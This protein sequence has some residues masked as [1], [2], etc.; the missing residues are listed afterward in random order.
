MRYASSGRYA[1][2]LAAASLAACGGLGAPVATPGGLSNPAINKSQS[3]LYVTDGSNSVY[4]V[5]LP[6]GRLA[7]KL[8]GLDNPAGLCVDRSGDVFVLNSGQA[9]IRVYAHGAKSAFRVLN[10]SSWSPNGCSV[11]P[12]TGNLAVCNLPTTQAYGTIAVYAKARGRPHSYAHSLIGEFWSC[13]YDSDGN[14][15]ADGADGFTHNRIFLVELPR[16]GKKLESVSLSPA[17]GGS[18]MPPLFWDGKHLAITSLSSAAI[19]EYQ[20]TGSAATRVGIV[21]LDGTRQITGPFWITSDGAKR[22]LYAPILANGIASVK[23]TIK[24]ILRKNDITTTLRK[25]VYLLSS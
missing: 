3:L 13:G 2:I 7:G 18:I 10:D 5:G 9:Q 21:R 8:P 6:S 12:M 1:L 24:A 20:I 19:D 22:T 15:F 25:Q 11:D 17:I 14:L 23:T 4:M 16:D